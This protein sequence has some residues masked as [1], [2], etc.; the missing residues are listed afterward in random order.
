M[1]IEE[2]FTLEISDADADKITSI[3]TAIDY[4]AAQPDGPLGDTSSTSLTIAQ[5]CRSTTALRRRCLS[6]RTLGHCVSRFWVASMTPRVGRN[7]NVG[8]DVGLCTRIPCVC[9]MLLINATRPDLC[10]S[11]ELA[12]EPG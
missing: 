6:R 5:P 1:A 11:A 2:E 12:R 7:R 8:V 9:W 10:R 4:V 3:S